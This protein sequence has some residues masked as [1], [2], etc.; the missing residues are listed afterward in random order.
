MENRFFGESP[1][2]GVWCPDSM[3]IAHA[4]GI[5]GVK[6]SSGNELD[7]KIEEVLSYDGPVICDVSTPEWQL[8]IPRI[9]SDKLPDGTL[10]MRKYED[11][12]PFLPDEELKENM[13][14]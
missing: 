12:F 2:T 4:Y 7:S 14:N 5:K 8:I 3:E 10:V 13:I 9:S 6:I 1:A 11:M